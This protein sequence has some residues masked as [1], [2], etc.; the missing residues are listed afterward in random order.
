[1]NYINENAFLYLNNNI[2][3]NR[4]KIVDFIDKG[5]YG[6]IYKAI[7]MKNH[8]YV[9]NC[10]FKSYFGTSISVIP[11]QSGTYSYNAY[12]YDSTFQNLY[13][14]VGGVVLFSEMR[15]SPT[16]I[17]HNCAILNISVFLDV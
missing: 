12:I 3:N 8:I 16:N 1:M 5:S 2:I 6:S 7:D 11:P 10:T 17:I 9:A 4:Y 13:P 15:G 14:G